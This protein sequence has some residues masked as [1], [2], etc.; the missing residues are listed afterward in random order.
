MASRCVRQSG[1]Y[2]A[3][4]DPARSIV[5]GLRAGTRFAKCVTY[6][7]MANITTVHVDMP[8]RLWVDDLSQSYRASRR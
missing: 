4:F 3:P 6:H 8:H 5:Q 7:I 1:A 2:P